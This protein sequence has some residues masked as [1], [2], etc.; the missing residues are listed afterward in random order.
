MGAIYPAGTKV[1]GYEQLDVSSTAVALAAIPLGPVVRAI[2][3]V[4]DQPIRFR[5]DGN[6][7]TASVGTLKKADAEFTL[8]GEEIAAFE[9]IRDGG[10]DAKISVHYYGE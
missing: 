1:L 6:S 4:E 2:F 9:A 5:V 10:T 7:P 3:V 8:Y